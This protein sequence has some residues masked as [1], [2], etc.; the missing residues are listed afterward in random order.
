MGFGKYLRPGWARRT[1]DVLE[2]VTIIDP[3]DLLEGTRM[4]LWNSVLPGF[5][6]ELDNGTSLYGN[7]QLADRVWAAN[8][9]QHKNSQQISGMPL[10]WHGSAGVDEPKWV[11]S[12]SPSQFPNGI[13]DAMYAIT[14]QLYG[15][16]YSLQ[17]VTDSYESGY[18]RR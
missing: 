7:A 5:Y 2:R 15:W 18:P 6:S 1:D 16:G 8:V 9:C 3:P 10:R 14:D 13:G 17:Y 4:S 12:P 11:S